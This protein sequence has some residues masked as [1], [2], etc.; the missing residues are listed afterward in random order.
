MTL[1][2][3]IIRHFNAGAS[4]YDT[5]ASV[6]ARVAHGL[7]LRLPNVMPHTVLEIGCGT[8]LFSQYLPTYF[9]Q[10]SL[11]LTDIAP[12]MVAKCR[13]KFLKQLN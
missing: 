12:A 1:K 5:T 7:T 8:G 6:Q 10:A 9:P 2:K 4:T 3:Q 11:W 13:Q